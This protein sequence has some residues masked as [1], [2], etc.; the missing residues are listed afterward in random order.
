VLSHYKNRWVFD[1]HYIFFYCLRP[2]LWSRKDFEPKESTGFWTWGKNLATPGWPFAHRLRP[3]MPQTFVRVTLGNFS[4]LTF[5]QEMI[6]AIQKSCSTLTWIPTIRG[7]CRSA[8]SL[9]LIV[10]LILTEC[11]CLRLAL[12]K[13]PFSL[14]LAGIIIALWCWL[15]NNQW[16][17]LTRTCPL[18]R[19][20]S[21][22]AMN[23]NT[24]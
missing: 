10:Q 4:S 14:I 12:L 11:N 21:H 2:G 1:E 6:M 8:A 15:H 13:F 20:K 23:G 19:N 16:E 22:R 17:V 18:L 5:Q 24:S 7:D 9:G 3:F